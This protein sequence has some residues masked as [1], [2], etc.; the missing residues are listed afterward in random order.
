M[1]V[2]LDMIKAHPRRVPDHK[3]QIWCDQVQA[4]MNAL[5][6]LDLGEKPKHHTMAEMGPRLC[7]QYCIACQRM[8]FVWLVAL[9]LICYRA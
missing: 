1:V 4:H 3:A 9:L 6:E 7:E 5:K 2:L 8:F